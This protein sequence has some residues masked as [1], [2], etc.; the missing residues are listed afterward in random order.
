MRATKA[1]NNISE[2]SIY[3]ALFFFGLCQFP[4][5]FLFVYLGGAGVYDRP[6]VGPPGVFALPPAGWPR[7]QMFSHLPQCCESCAFTV[8]SHLRA[9]SLRCA[10][11][12]A[13]RKWATA[14]FGG[15][16]RAF[17]SRNSI[18][19]KVGCRFVAQHLFFGRRFRSR[20]SGNC[21]ACASVLRLCRGRG[22]GGS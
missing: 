11:P 21:S 19:L 6:Q 4:F 13:R 22:K 7:S 1:P 3:F 20:R 8:S 12:Q 9:K 18:V 10:T 2:F 5:H 16:V 14:I 15:G 17:Q